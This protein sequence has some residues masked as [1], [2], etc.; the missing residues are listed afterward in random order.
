MLNSLPTSQS[1]RHF[2]FNQHAKSFHTLQWIFLRC[3]MKFDEK[4]KKKLNPPF[5]LFPWQLRQSNG[6][7]SYY[8]YSYYS[9]THVCPLDFSEMPW[10]NFMKPCRN[11]ICHVKLYLVRVDFFVSWSL[12]KEI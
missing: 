12:M 8:Y 5:S 1:F 2:E 11:I 10:S 4:S 3:F 9:S 7:S 6:N